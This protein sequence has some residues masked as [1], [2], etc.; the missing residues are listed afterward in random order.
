MASKDLTINIGAKADLSKATSALKKM[1]SD[2]Q[3]VAK[4]AGIAFTAFSGA[5]GLTVRSFAKFDDGMRSVKT[6]LDESSFGAKG[7]EKGFEAMREDV[8]ALAGDTPFALESMNKALFDT[9][10]AGIN[11]G[12]AVTF[13]KT[14][15]KLAVAGVTDISIAT[16]G[17]TSAMN[18][19]G[20]EVG[21]ADSVAAKFFTAQ[22][23]GKTTIEELAGGFGL[24]GASAQAMGVELDELLGAVSAVTTAGVDTN[25]AYTGMKAVMANVAKPTADAAKEAERLGISFDA[26]ALRS[27][28]LEGFLDDLRN[29]NGFTQDSITKLFGSTQAQGIMFAL[30]G[31]Q[32][33]AFKDNIAALGDEQKAAA[34]FTEA[35]ATQNASLIN[36]FGRLGNS[37]AVISIQIGQV[38]APAVEK[39][40]GWLESVMAIVKDNKELAKYAA[41]FLA[42]GAAVTLLTTALA[43]IGLV[44]IKVKLG[45]GGVILGVKALGTVL[46]I[47]TG[48][49][50]LVVIAIGA[51]GVAAVAIYKNWDTIFPR[52]KQIFRGFSSFIVDMSGGIQKILRG[53]F[54]LSPSKIKEGMSEMKGAM[55]KGI[56]DVSDLYEEMTTPAD[57]VEEDGDRML[58][59]TEDTAAERLRIIELMNQGEQEELAQHEDKVVEIRK[60]ADD[61]KEE[62]LVGHQLR[63]K[64]L[65]DQA[66]TLLLEES[67]TGEELETEQALFHANRLAEIEINSKRHAADIKRQI[68]REDTENQ[69][70]ENLLR[71]KEEEQYGE[72][73]AEIRAAMRSQE[74]QMTS[75]F[76]NDMSML[77]RTKNKQLFEIG[78]AAAIGSAIVNTAQGVTKSLSSYPMPF[79]AAAA[80]AHAAMGL[81]QINQIRAQ[82]L[83]KG[84]MVGGMG[85]D[86][87][88]VMTYLTPGELVVPRSQVKDTLDALVS[89]RMQ[90]QG[91]PGGQSQGGSS[92]YLEIGF[93]DRAF[94]I[95][96]AKLSERLRLGVARG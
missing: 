75:G 64:Q 92:S 20:L 42:T 53:I 71:L 8:L 59:S 91:P 76:L 7:L 36:A 46:A 66:K 4:T 82:S 70:K 87:D 78:K 63:M 16:D 11:A 31:A 84:G 96:E 37:L 55:A 54:T 9:V 32:A 94:E 58:A 68:E 79:A 77:T 69:A 19:Y 50:G 93:A 35:F 83:N 1:E 38:L 17:L 28:G 18:A 25:A 34:T 21:E 45:L 27:K 5:I 88:S 61:K 30:T 89:K 39:A 15:S 47:V 40:A 62:E 65:R 48:P 81:V 12:E 13:L 3:N 22:K 2:L 57:K 33:G 72:N 43:T 95:I 44:L 90:E 52:I 29:A 6:L 14:A 41:Y 60:A 73:L 26:A 74:M 80:A 10:S 56:S 24:V 49:I 85:P 51:L 86:A 67:L 23:F